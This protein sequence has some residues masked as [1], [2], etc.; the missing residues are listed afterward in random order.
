[1]TSDQKTV[2]VGAVSGVLFMIVAVFTLYKA[3]PEPAALT[4]VGAR[5]GYALKGLL[6]AAL[7]LFVMVITVGNA[8]FLGEAIDP[9]QQKEDRAM[10]INGRVTDNTVQQFL[11]FA[12]ALLALAPS[13]APEQMRIVPAAV[14]VFVLMRMVFWFGYR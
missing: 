12:V 7:P 4:D 14:I 10:L 5:I 11:L 1:M 9:T 3:W 13:L 8:R 6:F 2:A